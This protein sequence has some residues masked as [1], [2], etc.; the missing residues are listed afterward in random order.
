MKN[1]YSFVIVQR[2]VQE[3]NWFIRNENVILNWT[4][5]NKMVLYWWISKDVIKFPHLTCQGRRNVTTHHR[6]DILERN[7]DFL[8]R[9]GSIE[10]DKR[11]A[12]SSTSDQYDTYGETIAHRIPF[13]CTNS[14]SIVFFSSS[15]EKKGREKSP[16]KIDACRSL[17]SPD[18]N[19]C[20]LVLLSDENVVICLSR[21]G[22]LFRRDW[23]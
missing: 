21:R 2:K 9:P 13:S 12:L 7:K 16:L 3:Q 1:G 22:L 10:R 20:N 23:W 5:P 11:R 19:R 4:S 8:W 6:R 15:Q 17:R 14:R 18:S